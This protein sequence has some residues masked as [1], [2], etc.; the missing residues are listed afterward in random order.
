VYRWECKLAKTVSARLV[1][2]HAS[3]GRLDQPAR[4]GWLPHRNNLCK[5]QAAL[6][7]GRTSGREETPVAFWIWPLLRFSWHL[8]AVVQTNSTQHSPSWEVQL[9]K[10]LSAFME[11]KV[12]CHVHKR[13]PLGPTLN[14]I[15]QVHVL[16]IYL[17]PAEC[18]GVGSLVGD[19]LLFLALLD[20]NG[21][22]YG[23]VS[24]KPSHA[25][26]TIFW[27]TVLPI[28]VLISPDSSTRVLFPGCSR[29]LVAKQEKLGTKCLWILPNSI[30]IK[31]Q[32][33]FNMS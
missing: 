29:Q 26:A 33:F 3:S 20:N 21:Y 11:H 2:S 7:P 19:H 1:D 25:I 22:C 10:K 31:P 16:Q 4:H 9:D 30:S 5:R 18:T 23:L 28:W 15:S 6:E 13:P 12:N 17:L 14:Y 8:N 24:Y 27:S 32:V